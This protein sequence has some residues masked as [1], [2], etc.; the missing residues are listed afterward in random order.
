[1]EGVQTWGSPVFG[2]VSAQAEV[3]LESARLKAGLLEENVRRRRVE[4][5][6]RASQTS[7]MLGEKISH[8]GTWRWTLEHDM[9]MVSDEYSRILCLPESQRTISV[10]DFLTRVHPDDH[11]RIS[12][13][14]TE[15]VRGGVSMSADFRIL[16]PDGE[17]R[18]I[19]GIGDPVDSWPEVK[20][21]FGTITDITGQRQTEDAV[22]SAQADLARLSR[23]TTVG[24]LTASIAHEINQPL[25]SIVANAGASLRWLK[26]DVPHLENACLSLEEIIDEGKR[27]GDIIRGLQALT[28][29]QASV[30]ARENL[31]D[32]ARHILSLTRL[33]LERKWI[34]LELDY[35][36]TCADTFCDSVQIQQVLLNLH[37]NAVAAMMLVEDR[38]RT[39]RLTSSNPSPETLLFEVTDS[40]PGISPDVLRRVFDSFYTTKKEG[41][42]MGLTISKGI[43]HRHRGELKAE[44]REEGGSRFW[45]TLPVDN[46]AD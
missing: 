30:F 45:F 3:S 23:A 43:I 29:N 40:G 33:E 27:A 28:R 1:M 11:V 44:N 12:G 25:M 9:M 8:T 5:A 2:N 16:R 37:V 46:P 24:Q 42:G 15:S 41:M 13:L 21:Y 6:L 17:C 38:P 26:R 31:H 39:L 32:I 14:V 7:L 4:K 35:R 19:K 20:E 36:A 34:A 10:A 18:Y 22:R